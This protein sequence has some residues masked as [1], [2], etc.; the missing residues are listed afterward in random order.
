MPAV[1]CCAGTTEAVARRRA[2]TRRRIGTPGRDG[3]RQLYAWDTGSARRRAVVYIGLMRP[4]F[5]ILLATA[6]ACSSTVDTSNTGIP[7]DYQLVR[8]DGNSLPF[9]SA[10]T[11][12][13]RGSISLTSNSR[14]T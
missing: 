4:S 8:V 10:N 12:T 3:A 1:S 2:I 7:G 9:K 6:A 11:T 13:L 5:L 14:F